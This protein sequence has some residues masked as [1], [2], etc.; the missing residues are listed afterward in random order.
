VAYR[1]LFA[2]IGASAQA[3]NDAAKRIAR[4]KRLMGFVKND[5]SRL[6]KLLPASEREKLTQYT[7]SLNDM[8][9]RLSLTTDSSS[10]NPAGLSMVSDGG[11]EEYERMAVTDELVENQ[12]S[13]G[14]NALLCGLSRV[15][16]LNFGTSSGGLSHYGFKKLKNAGSHH[17]YH[18][19]MNPDALLEID[20]YIFGKVANFWKR[21][22]EVS[23]GSG[24]MADNTVMLIVNDGGGSH[25]N[26]TD[27]LPI[28]LMGSLGGAFRTGRFVTLPAKE[29]GY[30]AYKGDHAGSDLF[31]SVANAMGVP[32]TTFGDPTLCRGPLAVLK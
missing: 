14:F 13:L 27:H 1:K 25:H 17:Q 10:C 23:E 24:T 22:R 31:V 9:M 29:S 19:A 21:L 16:T 8:E 12:L 4:E 2:D 11:S 18:H 20:Q 5:L 6:N 26:G 28:L 7:D 15:L 3:K 30:E 32:A